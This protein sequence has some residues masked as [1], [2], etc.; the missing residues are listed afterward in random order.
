MHVKTIFLLL[1][2]RGRQN[3]PRVFSALKI[4]LAGNCISSPVKREIR[5]IRIRGL[6]GIVRAMHKSAI[7]RRADLANI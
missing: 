7:R 5:D 4:E 2:L 6:T 1:S 3:V